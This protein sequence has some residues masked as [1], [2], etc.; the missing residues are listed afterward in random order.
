[1]PFGFGSSKSRKKSPEAPAPAPT[2]AVEPQPVVTESPVPALDVDKAAESIQ[3][4]MRGNLSRQ[5]TSQLVA[6]RQLE[7][8]IPN[9][10]QKCLP[11]LAPK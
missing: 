4:R 10:L 3:K 7:P 2:I 6:H 9:A 8:E 5:Q 1:M 11:C